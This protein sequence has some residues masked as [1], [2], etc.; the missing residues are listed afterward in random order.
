[1]GGIRTD[2]TSQ[3]GSAEDVDSPHDTNGCGKQPSDNGGGA[4]SQWSPSCDDIGADD[5][6]KADLQNT[7]TPPSLC[8]WIFERLHDAGVHP[9]TILDPCAGQGNLT[10]PFRP[11][12]QVVEFEIALGKD[13]FEAKHVVCDLAICNPPWSDAERWLRELVEV[14]GKHTPLVF[15][16]PQLFFSGYKTAPC[17]SYL[18]S[19]EAP[20][21][22]H[23]TPLP[24][25]TFVKVYSPG[26]ILWCNLPTVRNVAL[27]PSRCLIRLNDLGSS[28]TGTGTPISNGDTRIADT[29]LPSPEFPE[30]ALT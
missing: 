13:F 8:Q 27:V 3:R 26:A 10:R 4:R 17:R 14:I 30:R 12:S 25:D 1:M 24:C 9:A 15:I 18:E 6:G 2:A 23:I 19:A 11:R 5:G 29:V 21:V 20:T 22:N 16:C 28:C 7:M